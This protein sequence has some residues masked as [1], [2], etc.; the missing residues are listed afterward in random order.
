MSYFEI[1]KYSDKLY[2]SNKIKNKNQ[3]G[4]FL[5]AQG[6]PPSPAVKRIKNQKNILINFQGPTPSARVQSVG[7]QIIK[8]LVILG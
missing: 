6:M 8:K 1:L 7:E 3:N 2:R 4:T 5:N